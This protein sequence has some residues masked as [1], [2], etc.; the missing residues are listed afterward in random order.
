[1]SRSVRLCRLDSHL[2]SPQAILEKFARDLDFPDWFGRNL[3]ALYDLL[4]GWVEGPVRIVWRRD[5][6]TR[7]ELGEWGEALRRLLEEVAA[8][9][10]DVEVEIRDCD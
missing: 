3:D 1:M 8:E 9:R 7:R 10:Q 6:R 4:T 5:A 2:R